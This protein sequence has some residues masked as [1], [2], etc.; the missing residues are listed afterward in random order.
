MSTPAPQ[1]LRSL[2]RSLL[3]ELPPRTTPLS[4]TLRSTFAASSSSST[5]STSTTTSSSSA[6]T[7]LQKVQEAEQLALY[8]KAQRTY[9]TLVERYNPGMNMNEEERVRLTARRVGMDLPVD[10]AKE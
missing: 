7:E 8:L 6:K 5:T 9:V 10:Y 2:Y 3:R 4:H 1:T